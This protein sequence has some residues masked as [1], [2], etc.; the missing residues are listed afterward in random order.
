MLRGTKHRIRDDVLVSIHMKFLGR[1]EII[2]VKFPAGRSELSI[3]ISWG[4]GNKEKSC[5]V[6]ICNKM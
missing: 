5:K 3:P 1:A 6:W 4:R 2:R